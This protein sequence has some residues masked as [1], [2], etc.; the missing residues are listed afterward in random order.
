M[1]NTQALR[2]MFVCLFVFSFG[3]FSEDVSPEDGSQ[4]WGIALNISEE[5]GYLEV[6]QQSQESRTSEYYY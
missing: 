3:G 2:I 1:K 4:L 6:L 5:P